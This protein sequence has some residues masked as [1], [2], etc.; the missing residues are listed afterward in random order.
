[1]TFI[2]CLRTCTP[3]TQKMKLKVTK[4]IK[5]SC[6]RPKYGISNLN[7]NWKFENNNKTRKINKT[8]IC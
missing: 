1:M 3:S 6:N 4:L 7:A 2:A 8:K 5:T